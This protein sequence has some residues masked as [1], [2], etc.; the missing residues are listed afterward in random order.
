MMLS[1]KFKPPAV[2]VPVM[3]LSKKFKPPAVVVP[4]HDLRVVQR[5]DDDLIL[6]RLADGTG[7]GHSVGAFVV[8]ASPSVAAVRLDQ[9]L[10]TRDSKLD[11]VVAAQTPDRRQ[12]SALWQ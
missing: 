5:L 7:P 6:P 4:S 12:L 2:V 10:K 11:A 3:M 8:L 1:K 9:V